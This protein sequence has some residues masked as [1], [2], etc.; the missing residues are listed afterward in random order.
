MGRSYATA[1]LL[2]PVGSK[3]ANANPHIVG[4]FAT[5]GGTV[6]LKCFADNDATSGYIVIT[7]EPVGA[8]TLTTDE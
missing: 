3:A 6:A 2:G 4:V 7:A 5:T 1:P 8:I